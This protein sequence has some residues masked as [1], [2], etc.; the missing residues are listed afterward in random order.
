MRYLLLVFLLMAQWAQAQGNKPVMMEEAILGMVVMETED[1][2]GTGLLIMNTST[3]EIHL[4]SSLSMFLKDGISYT[5]PKKEWIEERIILSPLY[6][7]YTQ[8]Y[9]GN[10]INNAVSNGTYEMALNVEILVKQSRIMFKHGYDICAVLLSGATDRDINKNE[11]PGVG[12]YTD[13]SFIGSYLYNDKLLDVSN[14]TTIEPV[15]VYFPVN[16]ELLNINQSTLRRVN[17]VETNDEN[18]FRLNNPAQACDQVCR[19]LFNLVPED[20]KRP[21][22]LL[23]FKGIENDKLE[24]FDKAIFEALLYNY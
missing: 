18:T 20:D 22:S 2:K 1:R 3:N 24:I 15:A 6:K 19:P 16:E 21:F 10:N 4:I 8:Q 17:Y 13:A 12:F 7:D 14:E 11:R 5:E 23:Q 9:I